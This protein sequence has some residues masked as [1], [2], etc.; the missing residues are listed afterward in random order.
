L[1]LAIICT[2]IPFYLLNLGMR[3]VG[4]GMAAVLSL[5]EVLF[6]TLLGMLVYGEHLA[7]IGWIGGAL[8]GLGVLYAMTQ[9]D[10]QPEAEGGEVA[11]DET[12]RTQRVWRALLGLGLL[13]GGIVMG[14][15]AVGSSGL[16]LALAGLVVLA[17]LGPGV[18]HAWL[19]GRFVRLI[20]WT[21]A[22]IAAI[23]AG[24]CFLRTGTLEVSGSLWAIVLPVSVVLLDRRLARAETKPEP[25]YL[26]HLA[27]LLLAGGHALGWMQHGMAVPVLESAN[28][29]LGWA[30][31]GLVV[32]GIAGGL[33]QASPSTGTALMRF[34][35]PGRWAS[36]GRRPYALAAGLW[37][38]GALHLVPTGHVG[39]IER[40]GEPISR[41]SGAGLV[42]RAP[43]PIETL[44]VVDVSTER[45]LVLEERTLLTSDQSMV[46]LQGVL[47]FSV[48]EPEQFA[49]G[50]AVPDQILRAS[51][52]A[53]LVKVVVR[54]TQDAV[55]T[56]GRAQ[57]EQEVL[58]ATQ[59]RADSVGLGVQ[60]TAIHLT[61]AS[62]PPPV[63]AAFLD[64][65]SADEERQTRINEGEAYA[66]K[67]VPEARGQA[68]ASLSEAQGQAVEIQAE[69]ESEYAEFMAISA[70]GAAAPSLTRARMSWESLE[71]YLTP[72]RLI[73]APTGVRVWWGDMGGSP[74]VD[75]ENPTGSKR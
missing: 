65:I 53:A 67:V 7:P 52:Q 9:R 35:A 60:V 1:G 25:Q 73:L 64:V 29:V 20:G 72:A 14:L 61:Q 2:N 74:P 12:T 71:K 44:T 47:H 46:S 26:L 27:L 50:S 30:G 56:T 45:R 21:G 58:A 62:V 32:A 38:A 54:G 23:A 17:R 36:Q 59:E 69:A 19:D 41:T 75:I 10:D 63:L 66:A 57:V 28:L 18:A 33:T 13:N 34:E 16:V 49:Y 11:L 68:L 3:S 70:G 4:A 39:I 24:G 37:L 40:F 42:V 15:G 43:A 8:A 48:S 31:V 6:A 5:S 51:A 55:L 22:A